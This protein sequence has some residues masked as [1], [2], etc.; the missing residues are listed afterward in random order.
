MFVTLLILDFSKPR[1][2][3]GS[4]EISEKK[5]GSSAEISFPKGEQLTNSVSDTDS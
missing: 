4:S 1:E 2:K 3:G 5:G